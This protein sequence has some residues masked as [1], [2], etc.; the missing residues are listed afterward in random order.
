MD[1]LDKMDHMTT[2][3]KDA[4]TQCN[5]PV[6]VLTTNIKGFTCPDYFPELLI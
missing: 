6:L 2:P 4:T 3:N 5:L 1:D